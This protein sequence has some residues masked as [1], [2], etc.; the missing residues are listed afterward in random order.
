MNNRAYF[1]NRERAKHVARALSDTWLEW[2][3]DKKPLINDA[4]D[5]GKAIA[6]LSKKG[7]YLPI[8]S[9]GRVNGLTRIGSSY[10]GSFDFMKLLWDYVCKLET[11]VRYKGVV[12]MLP[13]SGVESTLRRF[14]LDW[15][16]FV[17][18]VYN[19]IPYS[20]LFDYFTN[21]GDLIDAAC[22]MNFGVVWG[23]KTI[24]QTI[25]TQIPNLRHDTDYENS[26]A[27][28]NNIISRTTSL[29]QFHHTS[30]GGFRSSFNAADTGVTPLDL[31]LKVPGGGS[32]KWLNIAGLVTSRFL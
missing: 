26:S 27:G 12:E 4:A 6:E 19:L 2:A 11:T 5:L 9:T 28:L 15:T 31:R 18:T 17:P 8:Q 3:L 20:F 10:T 1:N 7:Q 29:R 30:V 25:N 32:L 16:N 21:A 13:I 22:T 23:C 14:G 24:R